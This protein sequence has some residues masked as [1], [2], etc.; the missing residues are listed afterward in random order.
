MMGQETRNKLTDY[1]KGHEIKGEDEYAIL[2][3]II[4]SQPRPC[5]FPVPGVK[6]VDCVRRGSEPRN[7]FR[8]TTQLATPQNAG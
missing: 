7:A 5:C 8:T 3:N 2:T 6:N 1:W 4:H